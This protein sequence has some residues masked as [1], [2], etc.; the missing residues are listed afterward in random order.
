MTVLS[1]TLMLV[2]SHPQDPARE[3]EFN[4]WY[5]GNHVPDVL[6]APNFEAA[7]R[8]KVVATLMGHVPAYLAL[9]Y[10][11][12][13]DVQTA[14]RELLQYLKADNPKRMTMPPATGDAEDWEVAGEDGG[15]RKGGLVSVDTWAWYTKTRESGENRV[16]PE[17]APKAL[18]CVYSAPAEGANIEEL[19]G[20]YER[21]M[22]DVMSSPGFR[23]AAFYELESLNVG[24]VSRWC[25]IYQLDT[26]D[27]DKVQAELVKTLST[28]PA[29]PIPANDEGKP[30]LKVDGYAYLTQAGAP[31]REHTLLP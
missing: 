10:V 20:W 3:Q 30:M 11:S 19:N 31:T 23:G 24:T 28:A 7:I 22:E 29:G 25:A 1:N 12:Q 14:N 15:K 8:Y 27:V 9:Y 6:N 5:N 26:D 18:L 21:H 2:R 13:D 4:D 17:D 16:S